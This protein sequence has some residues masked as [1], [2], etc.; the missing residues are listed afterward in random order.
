MFDI[1]AERVNDMKPGYVKQAGESVAEI[2][3]AWIVRVNDTEIYFDLYNADPIG[4]S[5]E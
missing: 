1:I 2:R 3:P 5:K 4:Y